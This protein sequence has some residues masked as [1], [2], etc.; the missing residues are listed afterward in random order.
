[1]SGNMLPFQSVWGGS[2]VASLPALSAPHQDE[3]NSLGFTYA[4]GNKHYWSS[5]GT[6]KEVSV[7]SCLQ[8]K[9]CK[10]DKCNLY[11][12]V[13]DILN[14][15]LDHMRAKHLEI[16]APKSIFLIDI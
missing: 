8:C 11:Q 12:W 7:S 16:K 3:A 9:T 14:P 1:M 6:T 15:Y 2:T 4:H 13:L 5:H 10:F